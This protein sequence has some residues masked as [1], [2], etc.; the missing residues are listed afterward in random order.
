M[1]RQQVNRPPAERDPRTST[2]LG[3]LVVSPDLQRGV[4]WIGWLRR[5][6]YRPLGCVGPDLTLDCPRLRGA[7]CSVRESV[8]VAIVDLDPGASA[9]I[10]TRLP[11]DGTTVFVRGEDRGSES[12]AS[13]IE[14]IRNTGARRATGGLTVPPSVSAA[15][16]FSHPYGRDR[17][18]QLSAGP[19]FCPYPDRRPT[20]ASWYDGGSS[21]S[22]TLSSR[23]TAVSK[24]V[25]SDGGGGDG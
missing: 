11:D 2:R 12:H 1:N 6:G 20:A 13:V 15:G 19:S 18:Q 16:V 8:S 10:C 21:T 23:E 25:P 4:L 3:G 22:A 17:N 14:R 7:P 24:K 5:A 9:R